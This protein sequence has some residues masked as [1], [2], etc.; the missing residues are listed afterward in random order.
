[1]LAGPVFRACFDLELLLNNELRRLG[2]PDVDVGDGESLAPSV[3]EA[4]D[5]AGE[6]A[7]AFAGLRRLVATGV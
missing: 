4:T 1:M 2:P 5:S 6:R 3:V 7:R